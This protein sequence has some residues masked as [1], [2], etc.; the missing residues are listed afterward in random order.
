MKILHV[1]SWY[2][3][4]K[5]PKE[6]LFVERHASSLEATNLI[7]QKIIHLSVNPG[8]FQFRRERSH[9]ASHLFLRLPF[10]KWLLIELITFF[11]LCIWLMKVRVNKF[12]LINFHIA[13]PNLTFWH[14]IKRWIKPKVVITE[15]WSAYHFN[16]GLSKPPPRIQHIFGQNLPVIA[17]SQ[18]LMRDVK[19][20]SGTSFPEY[21]IPNIVD[22]S[23]FKIDKKIPR[24]PLRFLM[25]A[26]WKKPKDP[27]LIIKAFK[28]FVEDHPDANLVIGGFGPLEEEMVKVVNDLALEVSVEFLGKLDSNGMAEEMQKA[29]GFIHCSDYETFSVVCAEALSCGCPV[30]ASNVGG[31]PEFVNQSNGILI[32]NRTPLT[33]KNAIEKLVSTEWNIEMQDTFSFDKVGR[34]YYQTLNEISR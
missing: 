21:I 19:T 10:K 6:A 7:D 24:Q 13:Y 22:T 20:F 4:L 12:D 28:L 30:I 1:T 2:P 5:S 33:L 8:K 29:T 18:A 15:H 25:A 23:I 27:F 31:I 26:Y 34:K 17:V 3:S 14:W 16:F 32:E 9:N 11:I